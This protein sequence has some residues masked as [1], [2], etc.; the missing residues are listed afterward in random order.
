MEENEV[1]FW[2]DAQIE[3]TQAFLANGSLLWF[4]VRTAFLKTS[5][6]DVTTIMKTMQFTSKW[7]LKMYTSGILIPPNFDF[8]FF[9]K[10]IKMLLDLDHG[11]STA[12]VLWLL[13][14]ILHVIPKKEREELIKYLLEPRIFYNLFFHWS[15]TVRMCFYYFYYFQLHRILIDSK[16]VENELHRSLTLQFSKI[17]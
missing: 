7:F 6:R 11:T 2:T 13:Y 12:K 8:T 3:A 5:I 10:G 9:L 14:Q 16:E 17:D 15:W 1:V 4:Y